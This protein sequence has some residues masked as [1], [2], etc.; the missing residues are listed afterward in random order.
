ML[1]VFF[2]QT[3]KCFER[4][5]TV[6]PTSGNT[7]GH[8]NGTVISRGKVDLV[9]KVR[10]IGIIENEK[11]ASLGS[12]KNLKGFGGGFS[13]VLKEFCNSSKVTLSGRRLVDVDPKY[14][15]EAMSI[16]L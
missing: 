8:N 10:I 6:S 15:L 4:V 5:W 13:R 16:S 11:P 14:S 2:L 1:R 3:L 12:R 7:R 9:V